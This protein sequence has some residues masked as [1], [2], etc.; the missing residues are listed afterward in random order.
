MTTIRWILA[1]TFP[2]LVLV[3]GVGAYYSWDKIAAGY[4]ELS[5]PIPQ[6]EQWLAKST[7]K[8]TE[9]E[10]DNNHSAPVTQ[11]IGPPILDREQAVNN[12]IAQ[13]P[14]RPWP[15][16]PAFNQ[17]SARPDPMMQVPV[18]MPQLPVPMQ[19]SRPIPDRKAEADRK[20]E[21]TP[22]FLA[23]FKHAR[24]SYWRG[25]FVQAEE[26]YL[27]II[28]DSKVA[29]VYGELANVQIQ[30]NKKDAASE[31]MLKAGLLFIKQGNILRTRQ[32]V[33]ILAQASPEKAK[34]LHEAALVKWNIQATHII[35][36]GSE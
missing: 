7:A 5:W 31:N 27:E 14:N 16:Y 23:K 26:K 24:Q 21:W 4:Q 1:Y 18:V 8:S 15:R 10:S 20:T 6:L 12:I 11:P 13:T 19:L 30:L 36:R 33:Y 35:L 29:D 2:V 9:A 34:I 25:N 22:A 28:K 17:Y 32:I 3:A